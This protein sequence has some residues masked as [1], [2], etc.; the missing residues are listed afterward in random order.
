MSDGRNGILKSAICDFSESYAWDSGPVSATIK[1]HW[2]I[3]LIPY[4][5]ATIKS[6][7]LSSP[8][9]FGH[10]KVLQHLIFRSDLCFW[11]KSRLFKCYRVEIRRFLDPLLGA[12]LR[13]MKLHPWKYLYWSG[14]DLKLNSQGSCCH[15]K[16][17]TFN[18][19]ECMRAKKIKYLIVTR[20]L[21]VT[22]GS[23]RFPNDVFWAVI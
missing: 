18:S 5:F 4:D 7:V 14:A 16:C 22:R 8:I 12:V 11:R 17:V 10:R 23:L 2:N 6:R 13:N 9:V 21:N 15:L 3:F 20:D 19:Q 1:W